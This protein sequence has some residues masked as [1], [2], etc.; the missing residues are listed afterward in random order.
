MI[1]YQGLAGQAGDRRNGHP[2]SRPSWSRTTSGHV[3]NTA[4]RSPTSS[5]SGT[6]VAR[7]WPAP[8]RAL[9]PCDRPRAI[10]ERP[11]VRPLQR[12]SGG[13]GGRSR[14]RGRFRYRECAGRGWRRR[15]RSGCRRNRAE[16]AKWPG[17]WRRRGRFPRRTRA[18]H[19]VAL[20][21]PT[22]SFGASSCARISPAVTEHRP[23]HRHHRR[24]HRA[25]ASRP[26]IEGGRNDAMRRSGPSATT[27]RREPRHAD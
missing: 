8:W 6:T 20:K 4:G 1:G 22:T 14:W 23:R 12:Q 5:G 27:F 9:N 7:K 11:P 16:R 2:A 10:P 26:E 24:E 15:G 18:D 19:G 21:S 13:V 17:C 25:C 3:T